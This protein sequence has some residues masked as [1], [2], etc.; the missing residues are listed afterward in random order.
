MAAPIQHILFDLG[1]VLVTV[2]WDRA[3]G[4]LLPY[5]TPA[6]AQLLNEDRKAF[7][8]LIHEPGVALETGRIDF[9][10]FHRQ[11]CVTL[12]ISMGLEQ[13]RFIWCDLFRMD[14]GMVALGEHLEARY[15]TWLVSNTSQAHYRWIVEKFP[16][17][18]F[19]RGAALSFEL[20]VMKPDRE[21]Y[22]KALKLFGIRAEHAL[23][24]DDLE[25]NVAG[26]IRCG[27]QGIV[28]RGRDRLINELDRAGLYVPERME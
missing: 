10:E 4:R 23:F 9:E 2:D 12:D 14:E 6:L 1:N 8:G 3:L 13:F 11:V 19:Y 17:V 28:F 27:I 15:Q 21:Y 25:E 7:V 16:R 24:I 20:G 5:L 22:E 26:A 18:V